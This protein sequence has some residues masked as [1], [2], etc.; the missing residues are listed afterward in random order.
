MCL[1]THSGVL[2]RSTRRR[3][4]ADHEARTIKPFCRKTPVIT[5][6]SLL[7]A[8][9]PP[10]L[11]LTTPVVSLFARDSSPRLSSIHQLYR[12]SFLNP[13]QRSLATFSS[14][15]RSPWSFVPP[16]M[17]LVERHSRST[18]ILT[19]ALCNRYGR[20]SDATLFT[21][22]RTQQPFRIAVEIGLQRDCENEISCSRALLS[23]GNRGSQ[24]RVAQHERACVTINY[25]SVHRVTSV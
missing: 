21:C 9:F 12:D 6:P 10:W 3:M 4:A 25:L 8:L 11:P 14:F 15:Y 13:S 22:A 20:A 17:V 5:P 16:L 23:L 19:R 1:G 18:R 24:Y 2:H 7:A